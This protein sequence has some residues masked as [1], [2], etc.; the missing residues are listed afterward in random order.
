MKPDRLHTALNYLM[1]F[2]T[3]YLIGHLAVALQ[4]V[5]AAW[6]AAL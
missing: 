2:V 4:P 1:L 5:A 6:I 3:L